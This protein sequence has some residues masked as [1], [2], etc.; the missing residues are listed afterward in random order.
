ML[1]HGTDSRLCS[2]SHA[3]LLRSH[4]VHLLLGPGCEP[5]LIGLSR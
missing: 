1:F 5:E 2:S 3:F 4:S